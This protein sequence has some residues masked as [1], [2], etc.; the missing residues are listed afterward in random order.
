VNVTVFVFVTVDALAVKV[1]MAGT[2][3]PLTLAAAVVNVATG[4]ASFWTVSVYALV[5]AAVMVTGY[6][7]PLVTTSGDERPVPEMDPVYA[8]GKVGVSVIDPPTVT[9]AADVRSVV[10][11]RPAVPRTVTDV[12]AVAVAPAAF[13]ATK[14]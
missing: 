4:F 9:E 14:V 3:T 13:R 11:D 10:F 7:C 12:V 2:A 6:S 8:T 5:P 1:T